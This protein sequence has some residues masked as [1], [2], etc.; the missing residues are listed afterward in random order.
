MPI[1]SISTDG[2]TIEAIFPS[3]QDDKQWPRQA[4]I[5]IEDDRL[6]SFALGFSIDGLNELLEIG[7]ENKEQ[8][9]AFPS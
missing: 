6:K 5:D 4:V 3:W 2:K 9:S 7:A 8:F 1:V